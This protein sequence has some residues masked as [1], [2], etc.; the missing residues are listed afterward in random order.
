[1]SRGLWV[2]GF[3]SFLPSSLRLAGFVYVPRIPA[4][5]SSLYFGSVDLGGSCLGSMIDRLNEPRGASAAVHGSI[6]RK[7]YNLAYIIHNRRRN[8][9]TQKTWPATLQG[10]RSPRTFSQNG[11]ALQKG[12][13]GEE[14]R[15]RQRRRLAVHRQAQQ[16][17]RQRRRGLQDLLRRQLHWKNGHQAVRA[18]AAAVMT[19]G[20]GR[21]CPPRPGQRCVG[22][23]G[24]GGLTQL[25]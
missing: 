22:R 18:A 19:M 25:T 6:D 1:M 23:A 4:E 16:W 17:K 2:G 10:P 9:T 7:A 15:W 5:E 11:N 13:G 3:V 8:H 20:L 24:R 14:E 21:H 12:G